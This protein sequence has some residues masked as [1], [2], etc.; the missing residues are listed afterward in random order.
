MKVGKPKRRQCRKCPW[1]KDVN[2]RQIPN[3]YCE[4]KHAALSNTIAKP[5]M[6]NLTGRL[7]MMACHE[8]PIGKE[9]ECIGWLA[10]QLGEGNN[11]TL[12]LLA[13]RGLI[14]T[15]F[16]LVGEQHERLEDTLPRDEESD[17]VE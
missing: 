13:F 15:N 17:D 11:I 12:R 2:P 8:S 16:E 14:D 5:G 3:G 4:R 1:R 9:V 10:H 6:L 7:R